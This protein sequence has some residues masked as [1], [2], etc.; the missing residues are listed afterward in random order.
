MEG[1]KPHQQT[2]FFTTGKLF[3]LGQHLFRCQPHLGDTGTH[4]GFRCIRHQLAHMLNG[5]VF[6][7]QII[8]LM[9]GEE[10]NLQRW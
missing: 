4:F 2:C 1:R 6:R 9:L 7:H 5:I 3:S 10:G 8:K